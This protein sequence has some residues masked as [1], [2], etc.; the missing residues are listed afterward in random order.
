MV[1]FLQGSLPRSPDG[2]VGL[3]DAVSIA[4]Y[5]GYPA[6]GAATAPVAPG[7]R[8]VGV[9]RR[10]PFFHRWCGSLDGRLAGPAGLR[11]RGSRRAPADA[12][13]PVARLCSRA[14]RQVR[15]PSCSSCARVKTSSRPA[16]P[17]DGTGRSPVSGVERAPE[18]A[19]R[20]RP[21]V[22]HGLR[23]NSPGR[24]EHR[25]RVLLATCGHPA[26]QVWSGIGE[27]DPAPKGGALPF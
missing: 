20:P 24:K 16:F 25:C 12:A 27:A 18:K 7:H 2:G 5:L 15:W 17:R 3:R 6:R 9:A 23:H 19:S 10:E 1:V 13:G 14:R 22:C 8:R 26:R 4:A 11:P 21:L